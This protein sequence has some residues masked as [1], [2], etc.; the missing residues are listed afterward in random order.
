MEHNVPSS[1]AMRTMHINVMDHWHQYNGL[2]FT[3]CPR[4]PEGQ[5]HIFLIN[6][7]SLTLTLT[8]AL[9]PKFPA[10]SFL[11]FVRNGPLGGEE[12]FTEKLHLRLSRMVQSVGKSS[13][14]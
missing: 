1:Q 9:A 7:F 6:V 2:V 10:V 12:T 13:C 14:L 4:S 3:S 8:L 11:L 5:T